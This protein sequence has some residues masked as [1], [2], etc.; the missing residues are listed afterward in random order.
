MSRHI[1]IADGPAQPDPTVIDTFWGRAQNKFAG[2]GG[3]MRLSPI[4][5]GSSLRLKLGFG[6]VADDLFKVYC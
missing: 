6:D 1:L 5:D 4:A 2:L 3:A